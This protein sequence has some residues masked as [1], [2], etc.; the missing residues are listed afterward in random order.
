[1]FIGHF[2]IA[3]AAK[4]AAPKNVDRDDVRC[5]A[6]RR[7]PLAGVSSFSAGS[8]CCIAPSSNPFLTL[9]VH[10]LSVVTQPGSWSWSGE[11]AFGALYFAITRYGRG[12]VARPALLV[13]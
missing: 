5:R 11:S 10:E 12:A 7:S 8:K 1:M 13:P 9:E 3:F 2:G 4:R 6:A